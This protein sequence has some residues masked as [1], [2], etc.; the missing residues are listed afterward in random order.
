MTGDTSAADLLEISPDMALRTGKSDMGTRQWEFRKRVVKGNILPGCRTMASLTLNAIA[1][2]VRI[3]PR[4]TA[5][6]RSRD[7]TQGNPGM[8]GVAG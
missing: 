7:F 1:A 6:T 8:T 5:V 3:F 2:I 4:M